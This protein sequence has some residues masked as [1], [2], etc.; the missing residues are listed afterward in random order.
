MNY[1]NF[2]AVFPKDLEDA[3]IHKGLNV[4]SVDVT[5]MEKLG[6]GMYDAISV[7]LK[8]SLVGPS[9]SLSTIYAAYE[10][11]GNYDEVLKNTIVK[12]SEA[13]KKTPDYNV[14]QFTNYDFIKDKL[15][16]EVVNT[17][18]N[19]SMLEKIPHKDITNLSVVYRAIL[20]ETDDGISS[21]LITNAMLEKMNHSVTLEQLHEDAVI[22]SVATRPAVCKTM[23]DTLA[24]M[25]G[26]DC[27]EDMLTIM[28]VGAEMYVATVPDKL[29]GACVIAYPNFLDDTAKKLGADLFILPSSTH[30][31]I[32]VPDRGNMKPRDLINMVCEVN[33][34]EVPDADI[35]SDNVYKYSL[36]TNEFTVVDDCADIVAEA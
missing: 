3:L 28:S 16:I 15:A 20:G 23:W 26:Y 13:I 4:E 14:D 33:A 35:L 27:D 1:E 21:V 10:D 17:A 9:G 36:E 25:L 31:V 19:T 18:R 12:F 5:K 7:R 30:E 8:N 6:K 34:T 11:S 22:N 24:E 2:K 32:I 29:H